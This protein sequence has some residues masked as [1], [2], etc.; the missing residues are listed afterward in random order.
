MP[1]TGVCRR[2]GHSPY[3]S[4]EGDEGA[5][6]VEAGVEVQERESL[7]LLLLQKERESE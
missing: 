3:H 1:E 4:P 2:W 5:V 7:L 6:R